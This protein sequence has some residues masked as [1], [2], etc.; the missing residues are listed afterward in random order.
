MGV[1]FLSIQ[2]AHVSVLQG[3]LHMC[4][5]KTQVGTG[6][7]FVSGS[8]STEI[9]SPMKQMY[10]MCMCVH[11]HAYTRKKIAYKEPVL[12][13][14]CERMANSQTM[15]RTTHFAVTVSLVSLF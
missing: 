2:H 6:H 10:V 1:F 4:Q 15:H 3:G 14:G 7:C 13:G 12:C 8:N 11:I 5:T 9:Q